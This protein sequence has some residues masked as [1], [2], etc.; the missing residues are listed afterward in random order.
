MAALEQ[1][2]SRNFDAVLPLDKCNSFGPRDKMWIRGADG[3]L[4]RTAV[5]ASKRIIGAGIT[6]SRFDDD[7]ASDKYAVQILDF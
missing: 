7:T 2:R 3:V 4:M 1:Q 5:D 6:A